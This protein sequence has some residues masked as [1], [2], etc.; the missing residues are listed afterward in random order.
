MPRRR[1]QLRASRMGMENAANYEDWQTAAAAYDEASGLDEWRQDESSPHYHREELI[2]DIQQLQKLRACEDIH[3]LLEVLHAS[4][5]RHH[6]DLLEPALY[7]TAMS[8]TKHIITRYLDE[9]EST[10]RSL[11]DTELPGWTIQQKLGVVRR[12][13]ANLGRSALL[14]S[15]GA[16]LGF[17][18]MGVG[19]ALWRA[20]LLPEVLS[21][22]SM[23]ALMAAGFGCR[24]DAEL[25]ALF[26]P[27][28]PPIERLGL[29]RRTW[30]DLIRNRTIMNPKRLLETIRAN[31]GRYTFAEAYKR[32]GRILNI[33][34]APTRARQKPRVLS[35][36]TSPDVWVPIA[37]LASSAV[38][39]LFPPVSLT[40]KRD[41]GTDA[42]YIASERWID[43]SL[44]EDLPM[45]RIARLHNVNHFI[46]SQTQPH[47]LPVMSGLQRKGLTGLITEATTGWAKAQTIPLVGVGR[48]LASK[49]ALRVPVDMVHS[50]ATQRYTGHIDIRPRFEPRLYLKLLSNPSIDDLR[51]FVIEGERAT[52]PKL[53]MIR[54]HTRLS[55]CLADCERTLMAL[56]SS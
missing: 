10:I 37:A 16:S 35:Y 51:H 55:R 8:G 50:I 23:G 1:K 13:S 21:G 49:T 22:S 36:R 48:K 29:E 14:M 18:H 33:S 41:D 26:T 47:V 20:G 30:Q 6:N 28:I 38:P 46:V 11:V 19:R 45:M 53:Q 42:P 2:R 15:G 4:L 9:V 31:C 44:G 3:R 52:W 34:V 39:G 27:D 32:S 25:E 17:Y 12:A 56:V 24:T 7:S 43:G 5:H 40:R 54:D